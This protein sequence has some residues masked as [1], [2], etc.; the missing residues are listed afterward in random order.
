MPIPEKI[1]DL[2]L[3]LFMHAP[4]R[5]KFLGFLFVCLFVLAYERLMQKKRFS[6]PKEYNEVLKMSVKI[7]C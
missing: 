7:P 4:S 1:D 6:E 2:V 3:K 5:A